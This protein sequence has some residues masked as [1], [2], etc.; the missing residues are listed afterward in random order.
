MNDGEE[1]FMEPIYSRP[2]VRHFFIL[3][4]PDPEMMRIGRILGIGIRLGLVAGYGRALCEDD[5]VHTKSAYNATGVSGAVPPDTPLVLVECGF[6]SD[7]PGAVAHRI[8]HHNPGDPGFDMGP[9]EFWSGSS[10]GQLVEYLHRFSPSNSKVNRVLEE[11][12]RPLSEDL[13]YA[14]AAD[15]CLPHAY[16]GRCPGIDPLHLERWRALSRAQFQG[17]SVGSIK[18]SFKR[19]RAVIRSAQQDSKHCL[20]IAGNTMVIIHG[21]VPGLKDASAQLGI[22]VEH[23]VIHRPTG[24]PKAGIFG[25]PPG[26]VEAW[27]SERAP[28]LG[29]QDIYGAPLRG[30]AGG[31]WRSPA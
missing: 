21:H 3:G 25:A 6:E 10:I 14:A 12:L 11:S 8:D 13:R 15:H 31:Y 19:A 24:T 16:Q 29:L 28:S 17:R 9:S 30:Y 2:G 26:V 20:N 1:A 27:M 4:A 23:H 18:Y 22:P 5:P 7:P